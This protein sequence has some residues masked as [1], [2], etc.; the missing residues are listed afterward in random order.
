MKKVFLLSGVLLTLF[1]SACYQ[2]PWRMYQQQPP[3]NLNNGSVQNPSN[4]NG[5]T[6][7]N[8]P[9]DVGVGTLEEDEEE[10]IEGTYIENV[11]CG[12][13]STKPHPESCIYY[14][15]T[16][17]SDVKAAEIALGMKIPDDPDWVWQYNSKHVDA[18]QD[19]MSKYPIEEYNYLFIYNEHACLGYSSHADEV[20]YK[21]DLIYFHFDVVKEPGEDES[22]C[23]AMDGEFKMA[24]IPKDFF[25]GKTFTNVIKTSD[26]VEYDNTEE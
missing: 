20:V 25:N 13:I 23:E 4:N 5:N 3:A 26:L 8:P 24:A 16:D 22:T 7:Q 17:E 2:V 11:N 14:L 6:N 1:M 9:A 19:M 18:F 15:V 12:Y 21:N 10:V